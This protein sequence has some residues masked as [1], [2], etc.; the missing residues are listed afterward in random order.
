[1]MFAR[2]VLPYLTALRVLVSVVPSLAV[3]AQNDHVGQRVAPPLEAAAADALQRKIDRTLEA[4][5]WSEALDLI[6][7]YTRDVRRD[8]IMFYNAACCQAQ[9]GAKDAAAQSLLDAV[10]AGF[11][12]FDAMEEDPDLEPIREHPTYTAILEARDVI[13]SR[14]RNGQPAEVPA[15]VP[16]PAAPLN[17]VPCP[18]QDEWKRVHG[19]KNYRFESDPKRRLYY[20]TCLDEAPHRELRELVERE[21]DWLARHLF[22]D[23]PDYAT[24]IAVPTPKDAKAYFTDPTTTGIYEHRMRM[25]VV[26]D[27]G[28]SLQHEFVHLMHYGSMER[29]RQKHP[30]WIQEGIATL[31]ENYELS[32]DDIRFLPNTRHNIARR[33]VSSNGALAWKTMFAMA[34]QDFMDKAPVL[35]PQVRSIFEYIADRGK[36][37]VFYKSLL[38]TFATDPTGSKAMERTF[39]KPLAD[40]ERQWKDWVKARPMIDDT[41]RAGDASLGIQITEVPE[42]IKIRQTLPKSAV[43]AAGLRSGD[44]IVAIEG[45]PV[46]SSRELALIVASKRVGDVVVVRYRRG[47]DYVESPVT[48]RPLTSPLPVR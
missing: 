40:I 38:A 41:V 14:A 22:D 48:L 15:A 19:E 45:R 44:V 21:A 23:T 2:R 18:Q 37:Q 4:R 47:D 9:L 29:A 5:R 42:G 46:R 30:I 43:R 25:L 6:A 34:P 10:K 33:A 8:P 17:L 26:R 7:E 13:K 36:L 12:E 31:F 35:Y 20:A 39:G 1:M 32:G 28:E 24:L 27:I 3:G 11:L 16:A